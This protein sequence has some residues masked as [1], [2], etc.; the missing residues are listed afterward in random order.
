MM[1]KRASGAETAAGVGVLL[2]LLA[3][4]LPWYSYSTTTARVSVDAF[5]ASV[6]GDIFFVAVAAVALIVLIQR[7]VLADVLRE[8]VAY[9]TALFG[10]AWCATAVVILQLILNASGGRSVGVGLP[11]AALSAASMVIAAWMWRPDTHPMRDDARDAGGG[12]A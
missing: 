3:V 2:G 6:L 4:F 8:R 5:R 12:S 9:R 11:F 1:A 7:G 10:A